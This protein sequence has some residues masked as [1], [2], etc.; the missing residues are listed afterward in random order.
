MQICRKRLKGLTVLNTVLYNVLTLE[1]ES[2]I[3]GICFET[4]YL[5]KLSWRKIKGRMLLL[6]NFKLQKSVRMEL[7]CNLSD[8]SKKLQ[9]F[10]GPSLF[11]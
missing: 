2:D 8:L 6:I 1:D 4:Y 9:I 7:C 5:T 10:K 3:A 11:L